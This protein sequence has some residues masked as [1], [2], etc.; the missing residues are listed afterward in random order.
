MSEAHLQEKKQQEQQ[1]VRDLLRITNHTE[2]HL[3]DLLHQGMLD[4]QEAAVVAKAVEEA[5]EVQ[6]AVPNQADQKGDQNK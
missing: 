6:V 3:L 2:V 4:L 1:E 5:Q